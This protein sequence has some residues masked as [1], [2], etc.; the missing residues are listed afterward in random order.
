MSHDSHTNAINPSDTISLVTP[1][2]HE[3]VAELD[4]DD[5][6]LRHAKVV[7]H[8]T[9]TIKPLDGQ[10]ASVLARA[11]K[12]KQ[13]YEHALAESREVETTL[14]RFQGLASALGDDHPAL[15]PYKRDVN[16]HKNIARDMFIRAREYHDEAM[17]AIDRMID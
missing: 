15:E 10:T 6:A 2:G 12:A 4:Y 8:Y 3:V 13:V 9:G 14:K 1:R 5:F 16:Q 7:N 11:L 17:G